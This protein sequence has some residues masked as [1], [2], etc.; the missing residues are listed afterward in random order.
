MCIPGRHLD[1]WHAQVQEEV[2]EPE[3]EIVDSHHHLWDPVNEPRGA[4]SMLAKNLACF[5]RGVRATVLSALFPKDIIGLFGIHGLY[6]ER[7]LMDELIAEFQG[8]NVV[9]S[10]CIE[11][12]LKPHYEKKQTAKVEKQL[13]DVTVFE[14]KETYARHQNQPQGFPHAF[15]AHVN[16]KLGKEKVKKNLEEL[17]ELNPL[18]KGVR[19]QAAF[20][21]HKTIYSAP[22]ADHEMLVSSEF[23]DGFEVLAEKGLSFDAY[24]FHTQINELSKLA[25]K[26]PS[27]PIILDHIGQPLGYGVFE[28]T[29][30]STMT[31]WKKDITALA[32]NANVWCKL[33]G[34][35]CACGWGFEKQKVPPNSDELVEIILPYFSH[36]ITEFGVDRC[37]FGSNF[38]VDKTSVSY[39]VMW[40]AY[41]KLCNKLELS[42]DDKAKLFKV[43]AT[44]FYSLE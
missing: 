4:V 34:I 40:N 29:S 24:I 23:Q 27:V 25:E 36:C 32:K 19:H 20:H 9:K 2:V 1:K 26:F 37:M 38:P 18:L 3:L 6:L 21:K 16:L 44:N 7:Y 42:D 28:G 12:M 39:L 5:P 22:E 17:M 33:S 43:N 14:A 11:S 8:H 15:V 10:V 13:H 31:E 35:M 30:E 41:K